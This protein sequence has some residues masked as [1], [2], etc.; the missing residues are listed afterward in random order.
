MSALPGASPARASEERDGGDAAAVGDATVRAW[1][2]D[3]ARIRR[4]EETLLELFGRGEIGGT[5]HTCIGQ[6]ANAVGVIAHLDPRATSS[7]AATAATGGTWRSPATST[8]CSA[9]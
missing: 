4:F 9:R 1:Y 2:R 5:T 8:A 3:L 6:E 7:S